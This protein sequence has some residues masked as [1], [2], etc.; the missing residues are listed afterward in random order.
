[1]NIVSLSINQIKNIINNSDTPLNPD[2]L[3]SLKSDKRKGVQKLYKSY[4]ALLKKQEMILQKSDRLLIQ[5]KKLWSQGYSSIAGLDEAG[6][7]PLAGPVVA[8]CVV[9]PVGLAIPHIDD[10]KKLSPSMREDLYQ[11]I[12]DKALSVGIGHISPKRIDEINILK[13]THEA[14]IQALENCSL[15]PDF[16]LIDALHLGAC[17]IPQLSIVKGDAKSQSIAA[18]SIVAKVIRDREMLKWHREYPDY[19]FDRNKGYGT[20][21]HIKVLHER[22]LSPIHRVSFTK[23]LFDEKKIQGDTKHEEKRVRELGR[24]AGSE[25]SN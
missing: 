3:K 17:S 7:G 16:L 13:A 6:R 20:A 9:L 18:A 22:G 25:V 15:E 14:M 11:I 4:C 1:M 2:L 19:H 12:M 8:A 5:E 10:S 21:E 24:R 23:N